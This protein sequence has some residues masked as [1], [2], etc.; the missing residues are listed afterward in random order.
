MGF[1]DAIQSAAAS[2]HGLVL[3]LPLSPCSLAGHQPNQ[4]IMFLCRS[5]RLEFLF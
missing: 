4:G 3:T 1:D 5:E 2:V